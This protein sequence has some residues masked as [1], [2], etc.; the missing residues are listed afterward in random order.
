MKQYKDAFFVKDK[1]GNQYRVRLKPL[2][3]IPERY[4]IEQRISGTNR[5]CT[6]KEFIDGEVK[7]IISSTP[8][9]IRPFDKEFVEQQIKAHLKENANAKA[10][11]DS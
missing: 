9:Y 10:N 7:S 8:R 4:V 6:V 3:Y 11:M 1:K 2:K 5:Y